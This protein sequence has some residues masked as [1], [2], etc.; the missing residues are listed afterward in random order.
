MKGDREL[1]VDEILARHPWPPE[2]AAANR[3]EWL[4]SFDVP[5]RP[6]ELW[7]V[8]ADS[9]RL[10][11]SLGVAE[12]KFEERGAVNWG[13][14][15]PGGVPHAWIEV[16]WDWVA[17]QWLRSV[18]LYERGFSRVVYAVFLLTP[19]PAPDGSETRLYTYF[20]AV[21]RGPIGALALRFGFRSVEKA[22]R[23]LWPRVVDE[24]RRGQPALVVESERALDAD[25]AARLTALGEG[26]VTQGLDRGCVD[27]LVAWI[28]TGDEQDLHRI[29]V[30]E[31][32]RA[33]SVD[34]DALLRV[35]LHAT[36]AGMLDLSWDV[37]CPHCRG[38]VAATA[39]LGSVTAHGDCE[40]CGIDFRTDA[41]EA[42][43]ITFHVH[44]SIRDVPKRTYCSAEPATKDHIRVQLAVAAGAELVV[45]PALEPG[46]Y[47]MRVHGEK[48]YACL[49]VRAGAATEIVWRAGAD[50][51]DCAADP[52]CRLRLVNDGTEPQTF[53]V[54]VARWTDAALRPGRLL[55]FQEFRDL[56]SEEYLGADVELGIGEQT[57]LF[58]DIVGS[59]ALYAQR[60]DPAAFVEVKRHFTEVFAIIAANRG[61][62]VKTIGDAA[63]GA[64]NSPLDAVKASQQIHDRFHQA[65]SDAVVRLRISLNTGPCIAVK[66]NT[67]I[68]YFGHTV[69]VAAK[70]QALAEAWQVAMSAAVFGAPGV[71][72]WLEEQGATLEDL[73]YTSKAIPEPIA[74]KRW[75]LHG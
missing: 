62:V 15:R 47:R 43:E 60:G 66:L 12:M 11:R 32:A 22:F 74:V 72:A 58:T 8:V 34:E 46:R 23:L 51:V 26:L 35:F 54:E 31:R 55:S 14:S 39:L 13:T 44:P 19:G 73:T 36:R 61:A 49:D 41:A 6:E 71:A 28:R 10:N 29:Q 30:R 65:G 3:L 37:V 69:N 68:D 50:P 2:H 67:D 53:I 18:R 75:T 5:V 45:A 52:A 42:V 40:V 21:P 4:W 64:F 27:H 33:W 20:G 16:P 38:V 57:I 70:L 56:F 63:M 25:A 7:R 59:T 1:T 48:R 24:I 17:G 9:S